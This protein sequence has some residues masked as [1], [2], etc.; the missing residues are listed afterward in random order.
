MLISVVM[1]AYLTPEKKFREEVESNLEQEGVEVYLIIS[2]VQGDPCVKWCEDYP[3]QTIVN[4]LLRHPGY[5]PDGS[6]Y[7]LNEGM[8]LIRGD[9]FTWTASNDITF[10]DKYI[11]EINACLD[12]GKKVGYSDYFYG[13]EKSNLGIWSYERHL[14]GNFIPDKS[15]IQMSLKKY[16]PFS[17]CWSNLGFWDF[18]L[19]I[20]KFEG[21]VFA[22]TPKATWRYMQDAEA[23]HVKRQADPE[24]MAKYMQDREEMIQSHL[25]I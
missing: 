7:Q 19:R 4:P 24:K 6:F 13:N 12:S 9:W 3:V 16:L 15:V 22:Y 1:N 2:T 23:M 10:R 25:K 14:K 18:W 17:V 11:T 5:S 21:D 8:R 20:G